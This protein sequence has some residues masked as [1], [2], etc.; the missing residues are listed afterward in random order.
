[1]L[2]RKGISR[3]QELHLPSLTEG[4]TFVSRTVSVMRHR[5]GRSQ[6]PRPKEI[7]SIQVIT[8]PR[9]PVIPE[10][11]QKR[12][13][14]KTGVEPATSG[15]QISRTASR[16]ASASSGRELPRPIIVAAVASPLY[17]LH[18]LHYVYF[19]LSPCFHGRIK[20]VVSSRPLR[21]SC[22]AAVYRYN[23]QLRQFIR[24]YLQSC[25]SYTDISV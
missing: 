25:F 8:S 3:L 6:L 22:L 24:S 23:I 17:F 2:T 9:S 18:F 16:A 4:K 5:R 10:L 20:S 7:M 19:R 13:E 11:P 15:L 21:L 14:L 12:V 1:M